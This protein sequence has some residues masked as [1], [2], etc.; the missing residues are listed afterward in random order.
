MENDKNAELREILRKRKAQ[1]EKNQKL[2]Q[3][4]ISFTETGNFRE[5]QIEKQEN[6]TN[7][8]TDKLRKEQAEKQAEK[9]E[10]YKKEIELKKQADP[11]FRDY[12]ENPLVINCYDEIFLLTLQIF[13][14]MPALYLLMYFCLAFGIINEGWSQSE[15]VL[16]NTV[17]CILIGYVMIVCLAHDK[18]F[19]NYKIKFTNNHIYFIHNGKIKKSCPVIKDELIRPFFIGAYGKTENGFIFKIFIYIAQIFIV[20]VT[21]GFIFLANILIKLFVYFYINKNLKGF[22]FFPFIRVCI[23]TLRFDIYGA[24]LIYFYNDKVYLEVKKYFLQKNIDIDELPNTYL[25][26]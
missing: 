19:Y 24:H 11:N 6:I 7:S 2:K 17:V 13:V 26:F 25:V 18:Y 8:K 23:Q 15:K 16:H 4:N 5:K 22:R 14:F 9:Q 3:E 20:I 10:Q 21:F 12:D 1:R